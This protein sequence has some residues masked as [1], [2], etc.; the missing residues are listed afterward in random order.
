MTLQRRLALASASAVLLTS[1]AATAVVYVTVQRMQTNQVDRQLLLRLQTSDP[2][3]VQR[4]INRSSQ[5]TSFTDQASPLY[6]YDAYVKGVHLPRTGVTTVVPLS[7]TARSDRVDIHTVDID[8]TL[9]NHVRVAQVKFPSGSVLRV[10]RSVDDITRNARDIGLA[11]AL[12][13]GGFSVLA[14][15]GIA[16]LVSRGL[17]PVRSLA[18]ESMRAGQTGDFNALINPAP[19]KEKPD[20]VDELASALSFM[21]MSLNES[22]ERQQR[23]VDDAAHELR[24]PLTSLRTN[25]QFLSQ[26]ASQGR[27]ITEQ[28]VT[29]ALDD[30]LAESSE[31]ADLTEE[32][33][34][35]AATGAEPDRGWVEETV[36]VAQLAQDIAFRAKRRSG[37]DIVVTA[38]SG[39]CDVAGVRPRLERALGNIVGNATKFSDSG[40]IK[41][42]VWLDGVWVRVAVE[43]AGPGIA[44]EDRSHVTDRFW[45]APAMRGRPGSGLGLAIVADVAAENGGRL[46]IGHSEELGGARVVLS[47][48]AAAGGSQSGADTSGEEQLPPPSGVH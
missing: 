39:V 15:I 25:L 46:D 45:R 22:R 4:E 7:G 43:D 48:P 37:R 1:L 41:V 20:E 24:T 16:L 23:L 35:L 36:D 31:L 34:A 42:S 32:L 17:R 14:A 5:T 47:L 10:M 12:I 19:A 8:S 28:S 27:P 33:V 9:G 38:P 26:A 3:M 21:A 2:R 44:P 11:V 29:G 18:E 40:P 13:G 30:A 6:L